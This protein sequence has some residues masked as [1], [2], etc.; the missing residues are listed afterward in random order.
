M[1]RSLLTLVT[2]AGNFATAKEAEIYW[3]VMSDTAMSSGKFRQLF[4][5]LAPLYPGY[6]GLQAVKPDIL[7]EAL[8]AET[9]LKPIG[10]S[11]LSAVLNSSAAN[12]S[13]QNALTLLARLSLYKPD[14]NS[15]IEAF[16]AQHLQVIA[17]ETH[18]HLPELTVAAINKLKNNLDS[19]KLS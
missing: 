7:G 17:R 12:K 11:I 9:L 5:C 8:V 15:L 19:D 1:A 16:L 14:L 6:Q 13:R 4:N 3:D 2:L 18:S 10:P